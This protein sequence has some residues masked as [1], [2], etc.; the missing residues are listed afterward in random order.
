MRL[1][2]KSRYGLRALFDIAYHT[3]T[4]PAQI[5]D[6]SRR[7]LISPR[8]LEQIFQNLKKAGI[9]KSK[10]GPQGGYTLARTPDQITVLEVIRA[11][12]QDALLVDCAGQ[13]KKTRRRKNECPFEGN[14]VTQTVWK[15]ANDLLAELF[16]KL[17]LE[18]LCQR[19]QEMGIE[20]DQASKMMY[21]I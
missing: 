10:R 14:C 6:I 9:L 15:D 2:T 21:Y 7:Q 20:K 18:T 17:T 1:S 19:G 8:Y 3:G 4:A 5:Q 11:T 16:G 13:G 12:E